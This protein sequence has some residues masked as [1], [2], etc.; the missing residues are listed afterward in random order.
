[1]ASPIPVLPA[2]DNSWLMQYIGV[3][4]S[5]IIY[6]ITCLQTYHYYRSHPNDPIILKGAV[7][8]L[9]SISVSHAFYHYGISQ[10]GNYLALQTAICCVSRGGCISVNPTISPSKHAYQRIQVSNKKKPLV[11]LIMVLALIQFGKNSATITGLGFRFPNFAGE[12][13]FKVLV[14]VPLTC[15][16]IADILIA[17]SLFYFLNNKRTGIK[18]TNTLI[19]KLII[20][21]INC[22]ILCSLNARA[23]LRDP[24]PDSISLPFS[25]QPPTSTNLGTEVAVLQ[26]SATMGDD[27]KY[28]KGFQASPSFKRFLAQD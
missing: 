12:D 4:L 9:C 19:S 14:I 16:S 18:S 22:G 13:H 3:V 7:L 1:M 10:F 11:L 27:G 21:A 17:G 25:A 2:L 23:R 28:F 20:Y 15:A 8:T 5:T 24:R 6:G 26:S